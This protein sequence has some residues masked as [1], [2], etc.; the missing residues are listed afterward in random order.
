MKLKTYLTIWFFVVLA[1]AVTAFFWF[2]VGNFHLKRN[3][4]ISKEVE[5]FDSS[6]KETVEGIM[7]TFSGSLPIY[8]Y[9][10]SLSKDNIEDVLRNMR[11]DYSS[12]WA[13][14]FINGKNYTYPHVKTLDSSFVP[15]ARPW[16]VSSMSSMFKVV[17]NEFHSEY[18][19]DAV[20][21]VSVAIQSG[22]DVK[23]GG[24][25]FKEYRFFSMLASRMTNKHFLI[26]KNGKNVY[27]SDQLMKRIYPNELVELNGNE[28]L[29]Y[30]EKYDDFMKKIGINSN[31]SY[32]L[33]FLLPYSSISK[34]LTSSLWKGILIFSVVM[35]IIFLSFWMS[36][37]KIA[38]SI[39]ALSS[40]ASSLDLRNMILEINPELEKKA[41]KFRETEE[42]YLKIV[43]M[44]QDITAHLEELKA[45]NEELEASYEDV[46]K[47]SNSL[48]V[49]SSRLKDLSDSSKLIALSSD[50]NEAASIL[51]DK[52][53]NIY[54]CEGAALL[55]IRGEEISVV[56]AQG[57]KFEIPPLGVVKTKLMEGIPTTINKDGKNYHVIPIL[58]GSNP[59]ALLV[60][61]F[62]K[63][64]PREEEMEYITNFSAHFAAVLN[65]NRMIE[66]LRNSYVYLAEKFAEISEIYDYETGSHVQRVGK[67]SELIAKKLGM[68]D[69]FVEQIG[70]YAMIH[71]IG[72]L[73]VPREIL[74]KNGPLTYEE[75]EEM[76][77]HTIY[78][79]KLLG[80]AP[81]LEM[82]RNIARYHHEKYDGSGYP[83]GLKGN[84]IPIE[85]RIVAISDVY[86]ALRSPR[87]Y[88]VA[89]S[90]K[91]AVEIITKG[92]GRTMPEHF[93]PEVLKVFEREH[94]EFS[95]IYETFAK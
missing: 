40:I 2:E 58:F 12:D 41:K 71:D 9:R 49:E 31:T 54:A 4:M 65:S 80:D 24:I 8:V 37:T 61:M 5:E 91:K 67:Y 64:V 26:L 93:D 57:K 48:A 21:T 85:A 50:A 86:D 75:F 87:R 33:V 46:E 47:L 70:I 11:D 30:F 14:A 43:E 34:E 36:S 45:T 55:D 92:D 15:S 76:K 74:I 84:E 79:E 23:V 56:D 22:N 82:A 52:I 27:P 60:M 68:S 25:I 69:T 18:L 38:N 16:F 62:N 6:M 66:E 81:F 1:M 94:L 7:H 83:D 88:K 59:I 13:F 29:T 39:G 32:D 10:I 78:G 90:H 42:I 72:K 35:S 51:L 44:A 73:K 63:R 53:I 77:K 28:Y 17:G 20:V 19:H 89:F 3:S 95:R